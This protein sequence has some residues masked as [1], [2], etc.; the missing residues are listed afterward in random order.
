MALISNGSTIFDNGAMA[1]GFGGSMTFIK[2]L[3]ASASATLSFVDGT[4]GVVLDDTYKEYLFTFKN[5][6]IQTDGAEG[7]GF[8]ADTGTNTN[9]NQPITSTFFES[10]HRQD[11][12]VTNLRYNT[13]S[14]DQAQGTA[15]QRLAYNLDASQASDNFCGTLTIFNPSSD[16]FVKH[17]TGT[18]QYTYDGDGDEQ[19]S[20]NTFVAGYFNQTTPLT[21]FQFKM[22]SGNIDSGDICLY[23]IA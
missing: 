3:T 7:P 15:F 21:R 6:H 4:D 12:V 2:K 5:I 10:L 23:G 17:F 20:F 22:E 13:S 14:S 18:F 9:Y 8:Q 1:S 11:D 19:Y 16:T